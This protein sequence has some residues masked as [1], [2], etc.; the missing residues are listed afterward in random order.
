MIRLPGAMHNDKVRESYERTD[1][2]LVIFSVL[3]P[4]KFV[5]V[6][7]LA[8]VSN[9]IADLDERLRAFELEIENESA[10]LDDLKKRYRQL[11]SD[12]QINLSQIEKS[13]TKLGPSKRTR[14]T[15]RF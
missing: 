2:I 8:Q 14:N 6:S 1:K 9:R 7:K 10:P 12:V 13:R 11:E 4:I 3:R 15:S 5:V